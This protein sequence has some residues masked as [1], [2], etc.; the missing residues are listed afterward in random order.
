MIN[1]DT[2]TKFTPPTKRKFTVFYTRIMDGGGSGQVDECLDIIRR[3]QGDRVFEHA[4][5]WASGPSFIGYSIY[6]AGICKKL[7][8]SDIFGPSMQAAEE[9]KNWPDNNCKD[10]VSVYLLS[11]LDLLPQHETWDL[12]VSNP[13]QFPYYVHYQDET[14]FQE[15][16][17]STDFNWRGHKDLFKQA[18]TRLR[19]GGVMYLCE[20][21]PGLDPDSF[22]ETFKQEMLDANLEFKGW[23]KSISSWQPEKHIMFWYARLEHKD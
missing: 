2:Y 14:E 16:R 6:A 21:W 12:I 1:L 23:D 22:Q 10:D 19:P 20:N 15:N 18:K 11:N 4:Y 7:S 17:I 13:P 8:V 5:E 3:D 9:T